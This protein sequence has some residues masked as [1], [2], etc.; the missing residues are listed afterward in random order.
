MLA[1]PDSTVSGPG[2]DRGR[3]DLE[4]VLAQRV[5]EAVVAALEA[6][7]VRRAGDRRHA[8]VPVVDQVAHGLPHRV[9]VVEHHRVAVEPLDEAVDEHDRQAL[10][11]DLGESGGVVGRPAPR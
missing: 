10:G 8:T 9:P 1:T 5:D 7:D 6:P 3:T 4:T 2:P 11:R